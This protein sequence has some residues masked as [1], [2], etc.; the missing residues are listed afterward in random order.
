M[1]GGRP[2]PLL[3]IPYQVLGLCIVSRY[4]VCIDTLLMIWLAIY[5]IKSINSHDMYQNLY[6]A[7][8]SPHKIPQNSVL[9]HFSQFIA[10]ISH[11][12]CCQKYWGTYI[13]SKYRRHDKCRINVLILRS[14][15]LWMHQ[16]I[17]YISIYTP[18]LS[19]SHISHTEVLL[20]N[21][22]D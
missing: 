9:L 5:Q 2:H 17:S 20:I 19:C 11:I 18:N 16:C 14:T 6:L 15:R 12:W 4:I 21:Y 8:K 13:G 7:I 10:N 22:S 3:A 1:R